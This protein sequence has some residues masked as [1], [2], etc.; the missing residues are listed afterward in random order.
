MCYGVSDNN[1]STQT[2]SHDSDVSYFLLSLQADVEIVFQITSRLVQTHLKHEDRGNMFPRNLLFV[3]QTT[4]LQVGGSHTILQRK[5]FILSDLGNYKRY[6]G[7]KN[8]EIK[9]KKENRLLDTALSNQ[10]EWWQWCM[11]HGRDT[12]RILKDSDRENG[13]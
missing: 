8:V 5:I 4:V 13:M 3:Y 11:L 1:T 2:G 10:G 12:S 7:V 6:E 9:A